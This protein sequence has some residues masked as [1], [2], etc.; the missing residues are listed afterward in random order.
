M[1]IFLDTA[2]ID[3][4]REAA[5]LGIISGVTTN[6][7]LVSKEATADYETVIK[8]IL[9]IRGALKCERAPFSLRELFSAIGEQCR[10]ICRSQT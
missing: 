1:R 6:P 5:S 9:G 8:T 2:N 4:I 10:S 7:S 3:E